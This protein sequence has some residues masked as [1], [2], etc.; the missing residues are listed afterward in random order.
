MEAWRNAWREWLPTQRKTASYASLQRKTASYASAG[1]FFTK[2]NVCAC[3]CFSA[4]VR[5]EFVTE[6][7]ILGLP[8]ALPQQRMNTCNIPTLHP[9]C[10]YDSQIVVG[11]FGKVLSWN[12]ACFMMPPMCLRAAVRPSS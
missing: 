5:F 12:P 6:T 10:A 7:A 2:A 8:L 11:T 3:A 9:S 4:R 1:A